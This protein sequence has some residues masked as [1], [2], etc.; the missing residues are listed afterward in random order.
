M[1]K[2]VFTYSVGFVLGCF[3]LGEKGRLSMISWLGEKGRLI[4]VEANYEQ[5]A[6]ANA[7]Q[8]ITQGIPNS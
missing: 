4:I 3:V 1:E 7:H 6:D 5:F 2:K 8:L